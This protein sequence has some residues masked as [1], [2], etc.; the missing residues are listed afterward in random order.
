MQLDVA[1]REL[2][3]DAEQVG[4]LALILDLEAR[5]ERLDELGVERAGAVRVVADAQVVDVAATN[6]LDGD[7]VLRNRR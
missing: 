4:Q 3:L 2:E 6:N 5:L 1:V 7:G